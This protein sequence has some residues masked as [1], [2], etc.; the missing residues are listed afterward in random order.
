[1]FVEKFILVSIVVGVCFALSHLADA[2][3]KT[4]HADSQS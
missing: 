2:I 1:M 4:K 3:M